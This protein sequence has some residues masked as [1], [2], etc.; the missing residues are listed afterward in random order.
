MKKTIWKRT[1]TKVKIKYITIITT[2]TKKTNIK[3]GKKPQTNKQEKSKQKQITKNKQ[4]QTIFS[5]FLLILNGDMTLKNS[6]L[7]CPLLV[8][9]PEGNMWVAIF[10][11]GT[12]ST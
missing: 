5:L 7:N 6:N 1:K 9:P 2:A 10:W 11:K 12:G 3:Q 8:I 4:K